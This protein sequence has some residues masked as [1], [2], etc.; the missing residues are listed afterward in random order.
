MGAH[1]TRRF[2]GEY[3]RDGDPRWSNGDLLIESVYRFKGQSAPAVVLT[4]FDFGELDDAARRK[5]FVALTRADDGGDG[6]VGWRGALS[7]GLA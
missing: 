2:T 5:L 1:A 3:A 6:V 7:G 4:E